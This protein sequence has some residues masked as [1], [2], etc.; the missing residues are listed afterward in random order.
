VPATW[1]PTLPRYGSCKDIGTEEHRTRIRELIELVTKET[2]ERH[3]AEGTRPGRRRKGEGPR[4]SK[5][6]SRK[7]ALARAPSSR[8]SFAS[9]AMESSLQR[10]ENQAGMATRK[11]L[12]KNIDPDRNPRSGRSPGRPTRF[13]SS[14]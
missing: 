12:E 3:R 7:E 4:S 9:W 6:A 2:R 5:P 8:S 14:S 11:D 13:D 1:A 10:L